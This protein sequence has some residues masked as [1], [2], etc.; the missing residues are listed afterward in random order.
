MFNNILR[1]FK[2]KFAK[3]KIVMLLVISYLSCVLFISPFIHVF[4]INSIG[5]TILAIFGM[6][7]CMYLVACALILVSFK[8]YSKI[9]KL[10]TFGYFII[11]SILLSISAVI[12]GVTGLIFAF[13]PLLFLV[14]G[15]LELISLVSVCIWMV[16]RCFSKD[17]EDAVKST[18]F[19]RLRIFGMLVVIVMLLIWLLI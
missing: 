10:D 12:I 13:S 4:T 5:L 6:G 8:F 3:L 11:S 15:I 17:M 18:F 14:L 7:L 9:C 2:G 16:Y 19:I 1:M